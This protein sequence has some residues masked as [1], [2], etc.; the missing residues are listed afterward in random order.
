ML[1]VTLPGKAALEQPGKPFSPKS[2]PLALSLILVPFAARFRKA[3]R[4]WRSLV[5]LALL[6][7]ALSVGL[8]ACGSNAKLKSQAYSLTVTASLRRIV[9]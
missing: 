7:I 3:A 6:G 2:L 4:R 8:T 5:V 9:A 1:Q